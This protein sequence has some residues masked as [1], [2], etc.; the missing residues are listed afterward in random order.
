MHRCRTRERPL[1]ALACLAALRP[2]R[3]VHSILGLNTS[4]S[5]Q[6]NS[7]EIAAGVLSHH[8][9]KRGVPS[10]IEL[11]QKLQ[12][13]GLLQLKSLHTRKQCV[14]HNVITSQ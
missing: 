8:A 5:V 6:G 10:W 2:C 3:V 14:V 4:Y 13:E 11:I 1:A 7:K 12:M 9:S